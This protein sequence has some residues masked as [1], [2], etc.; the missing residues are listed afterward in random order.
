MT[1]RDSD[2][3]RLSITLDRQQANQVEAM[4]A[5]MKVSSAWIIR[6]AVDSYLRLTPSFRRA[7]ECVREMKTNRTGAVRE[8]LTHLIEVMRALRLER[9]DAPFDE[10]F[11]RSINDFMLTRDEVVSL[12]EATIQ[13]DPSAENISNIQRFFEQSLAL[14]ERP[15]YVHMWTE[16]NSD[17][18]RFIVHELFLYFIALL[19]KHE[20]FS[21]VDYMCRTPYYLANRSRDIAS[22]QRLQNYLVTLEER[23]R[24]LAL[25]RISLHADLL[26][27]R[28]NIA[29]LPFESIMQADFT[30]FMRD[31]IEAMKED[32]PVQKWWPVT[33]L[34]R[35]SYG[36]FEVFA[37]SKS[38]SYFERSKLA[39][40]IE[41]KD[42][43][44]PVLQAF[45]GDQPKLRK[46]NW[47]GTH[48]EPEVF[49]GFDSMASAR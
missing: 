9:T 16:S 21:A 31:A 13:Y 38:K 45:G 40:G 3:V 35:Q 14:F 48:V 17:N 12:F 44:V 20:H 2:T 47:H 1:S 42:A 8:Y 15:E 18:Y 24:R 4:A 41:K 32:R 22:F 5:Q 29:G 34:Y 39:L 7:L 19:L 33:L 27:D 43:L 36:P 11:L 26:H 6:E 37:R 10:Q 30:L 49:L 28:A 46:P 23:T 25:N